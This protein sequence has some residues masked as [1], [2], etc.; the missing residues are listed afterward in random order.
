MLTKRRGFE[1]ITKNRVR[2]I[3]SAREINRA[4]SVKS[5]TKGEII[6]DEIAMPVINTFV[7]ISGFCIL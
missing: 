4:I 6:N 2:A 3:N 5:S 1:R 7:A